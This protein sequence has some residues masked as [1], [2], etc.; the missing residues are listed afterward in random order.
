MRAETITIAVGEHEALIRGQQ[1]TRMAFDLGN[2]VC[3]NNVLLS[4]K[5]VY[6]ADLATSLGMF[7]VLQILIWQSTVPEAHKNE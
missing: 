5:H 2:T 7:V 3:V 6:T 4:V 1:Q